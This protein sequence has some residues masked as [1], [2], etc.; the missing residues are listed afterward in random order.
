MKKVS[1]EGEEIIT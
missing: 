1:H